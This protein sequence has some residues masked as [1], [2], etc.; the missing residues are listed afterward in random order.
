MPQE[1]RYASRAEQQAAYRERKAREQAEELVEEY[2]E[3]EVEAILRAPAIS[4]EAYVAQIRR[5]AAL[6][7]D[8]IGE[9]DRPVKIGEVEL[10]G[11]RTDRMARAERYARWRYRGFLTGE[12]ASL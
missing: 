1:K 12:V 5:E 2:V 3:T 10:S 7:A 4:E 11:R 8:S 6:Y 9:D